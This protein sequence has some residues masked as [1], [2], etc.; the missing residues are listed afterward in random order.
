MLFIRD[1]L[2]THAEETDE[3]LEIDERELIIGGNSAPF[4][5][6]PWFALGS[7][8]CGGSLVAPEWVL[9]AAHCSREIFQNVTIG[10]VCKENV[11]LE[12]TNCDT[13][14]EIKN[15]DWQYVH[16]RYNKNTDYFDLRLVHLESR[17][18]ISPVRMDDRHLSDEYSEGKYAFIRLIIDPLL[19]PQ[20]IAFL[21]YIT[22]NKGRADLW[23][24]GF[25]LTSVE[26]EKT[27]PDYLMVRLHY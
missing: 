9:T 17:S 8:G 18:T 2:D 22:K 26:P 15:T 1:H 19:V 23:T 12:G 11:D 20:L 21:H 7:G 27:L 24:A 6:Y 25:G 5:K 13:K 16:P 3:A 14:F 4:D 10:A